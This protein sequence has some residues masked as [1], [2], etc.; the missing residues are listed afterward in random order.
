MGDESL[1]EQLNRGA[2]TGLDD[3]FSQK[4]FSHAIRNL[5]YDLCSPGEVGPSK[6]PRKEVEACK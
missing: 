4:T 2:R 3:R 1:R 5:V 6:I